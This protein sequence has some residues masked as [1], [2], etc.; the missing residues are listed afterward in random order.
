M[1]LLQQNLDRYLTDHDFLRLLGDDDICV[2]SDFV[3]N[4]EGINAF[5][6]KFYG[7][8]IPHV[9]ISGI[10][11]GRFG[12]GMTGIP[13][14]D[15]MSLSQLISGTDRV[16]L[17]KSASFIFQVVRRLGIE[18]FLRTFYVNN[19]SSVGYLRNEKNLNYYDLPQA[20]LAIV[21]KNFIYVNECWGSHNYTVD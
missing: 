10:N 16:E 15:F 19:F 21:E 14:L 2:L 6:Q 13:L 8:V 7:D 20:A 9:M 18:T 1:N 12:A 4:R 5:C 17:E 11:P 3:Q